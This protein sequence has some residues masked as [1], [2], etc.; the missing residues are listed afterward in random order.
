MDRNHGRN[1]RGSALSRQG[2]DEKLGG[3]KQGGLIGTQVLTGLWAAAGAWAAGAADVA[4]AAVRAALAPADPH[5]QDHQADAQDHKA[6][7][8]PLC[9]DDRDAYS[10]LPRNGV[11]QSIHWSPLGTSTRPGCMEMFGGPSGMS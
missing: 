7:E 4:A 3:W 10:G 1:I 6:H 8:H 5:E 9:A 2:W 11:G